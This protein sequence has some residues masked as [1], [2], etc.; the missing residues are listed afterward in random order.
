MRDEDTLIR[1]ITRALPSQIGRVRNHYGVAFGIGD[2]AAILHS[3]RGEEWIISC[4]AFIEGVHFLPDIHPADSVGYKALV[5]ATSDLVAMGASPKLFL[6]TLALPERR[7]GH[8]MDQ[9]LIGMRRAAKYLDVRLAGGDTTTGATVSI[10]IA[11]LGQMEGQ[12]SRRARI[13]AKGGRRQIGGALKRSGGRAGDQIYVSG[14]LGRAQVGLEFVRCM[15]KQIERPR[16]GSSLDAALQPHLYPRLRV[17]L[18]K[19]LARNHV[20]S[21]MM[22]LS[23]GLS[24][25]LARLCRASGVGAKL[26]ADRIPVVSLPAKMLRRLPRS[27]D[28]LRGALNGGDDYELLFTVPR[29]NEQRLHSAPDSHEL[30]CVGELTS[31]SQILLVNA[32]GRMKPLKI[33]GWDPFRK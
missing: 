28:P 4:D 20:A 18:G 24:S 22:D 12:R 25:D 19:W 14:A 30:T 6:L 13:S 11:V 31:G 10:S 16:V 2:D 27:L 32:D 26:W 23:D 21:A 3:P 5:R 33:G 15:K 9:F 17:E 7:C 8:W 1:R 29:R